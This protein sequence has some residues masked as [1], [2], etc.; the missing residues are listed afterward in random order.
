MISVKFVITLFQL[1][2]FPLFID[3]DT[4]HFIL[5]NKTIALSIY[6]LE[7][8]RH[9]ATKTEFFMLPMSLSSVAA[10]C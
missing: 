3:N 7:C 9:L 10:I 2:Y 6:F 8:F 5:S 1:I 4:R